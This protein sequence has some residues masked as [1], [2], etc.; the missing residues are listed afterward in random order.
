MTAATPQELEF[1][2][3]LQPRVDA[4]AEE[5]AAALDAALAVTLRSQSPVALGICLHAYAAI[6]RPQVGGGCGGWRGWGLR[7]FGARAA[8]EVCPG[9]L[10]SM[11]GLCPSASA[12]AAAGR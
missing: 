1:M 2:R 12:A 10:G 3:Q 5:L 11:H 6:S 9:S 7:E 4:A 8:R